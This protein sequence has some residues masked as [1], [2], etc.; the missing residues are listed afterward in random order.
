VIAEGNDT[1]GSDSPDAGERAEIGQRARRSEGDLLAERRA[2]RTAESG[3]H[4]LTLRAEAAEATVRTLETHVASL[5]RRLQDAEVE[6]RR[7][8]E[9]LDAAEASRTAE[10]SE[11]ADRSQSPISTPALER[12]LQRASQREYAEQRLRIEA[13]ERAAERER[14]LRAE[15]DRLGRGLSASER[16][17][18]LLKARLETAERELAEAE[19]L[20]AAERAE[21]ERVASTLRSRLVELDGRAGELRQLLELERLARERAERAFEQLGAAQRS[22]QLLLG[23]LAETVARLRDVT[24]RASSPAEPPVAARPSHAVVAAAGAAQPPA[25]LVAKPPTG[26]AGAAQAGDAQAGEAQAGE[27]QPGEV[28]PVQARTGEAR[29]AEARAGEA[30]SGEMAESLASAFERLRARVEQQQEPT[31]PPS[32][33]RAARAPHK[34]SMSLIGRTRLAMRRRSERRKQRRTA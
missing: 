7:T 13:E 11:L 32:P 24:I 21:A 3:E 4:A 29:T 19:H 34:H 28:Q 1:P 30:H 18:Q 14:E 20:A 26:P 27:V 6:S 16:D 8:A 25:A 17:A 23:G 9:L 10:R 2:R 33:A 22:A 12:E 15:L 31:G 5:Q